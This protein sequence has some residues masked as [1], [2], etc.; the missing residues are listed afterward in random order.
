MWGTFHSILSYESLVLCGDD[1]HA[2]GPG[3]VDGSGSKD[4]L[5]MPPRLYLRRGLS[6]VTCKCTCTPSLGHFSANPE[7]SLQICRSDLGKKTQNNKLESKQSYF[8]KSASLHRKKSRQKGCI[9]LV[10]SPALS[11]VIVKAWAKSSYTWFLH[12][13]RK[14]RE[15][16]QSW[17]TK[18]CLEIFALSFV[19]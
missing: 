12:K 10:S 6:Y 19:C 18:H 7:M 3:A 8:Q 17:V 15:E 1:Q 11:N 4:R 13:L 16:N 14:V 2:Q 5:W 9:L